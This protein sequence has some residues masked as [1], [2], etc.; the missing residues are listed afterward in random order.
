MKW[1]EERPQFQGW[2]PEQSGHDVELV[3]RAG[4]L[5]ETHCVTCGWRPAEFS[6]N[7][8]DA[9]LDARQHHH[10]VA[11][12]VNQIGNRTTSLR[13]AIAHARDMAQR[14]TTPPKEAAEWNRLADEM[15]RQLK[16][17]TRTK[18]HENL[19]GQQELFTTTDQ[20]AS[21]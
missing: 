16:S 15:E 9:D 10:D 13:P 17:S 6:K 20:G 4:G 12:G 3:P 18:P 21:E 8:H 14:E 1:G 11:T 7:E 2:G 19:E 5:W